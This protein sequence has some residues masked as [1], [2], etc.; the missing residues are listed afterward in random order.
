MT[1]SCAPIITAVS[2][3]APMVS[4]RVTCEEAGAGEGIE[5]EAGEVEVTGGAEATEAVSMEALEAAAGGSGATTVTGEAGGI[6][7]RW[8][9]ATEEAI[10][11]S[12]R[13]VTIEV[14]IEVMR[15]VTGEVTTRG[16]GTMCPRTE[17]RGRES[18][19][20]AGGPR[21]QPWRSP[22]PLSGARRQQGIESP[23][24]RRQ[25]LPK[26]V[27]QRRLPSLRDSLSLEVKEARRA[28][29][30]VHPL[31]PPRPVW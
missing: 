19:R 28:A 30:R 7:T 8:T 18:R 21:R 6:T 3:T 27:I 13:V 16:N 15:V 12:T 22:R 25:L 4:T 24:L 31:A 23:S 1:S 17:R 10:G 9:G 26:E 11:E 20:S 29:P 14:D 5:V 2:E